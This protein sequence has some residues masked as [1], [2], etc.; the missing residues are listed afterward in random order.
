MFG[1]ELAEE[2]GCSAGVGEDEESP[3]SWFGRYVLHMV[4]RDGIFLDGIDD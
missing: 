4:D 3:W 1:E 2:V